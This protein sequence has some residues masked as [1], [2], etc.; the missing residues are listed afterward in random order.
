MGTVFAL[1]YTENAIINLTHIGKA[2]PIT[3]EELRAGDR[4][5]LLKVGDDGGTILHMEA[6]R[7][8]V[9]RGKDS[10]I[11]MQ[12][13]VLLVS[14]TGQRSGERLSVRIPED[15]DK[16]LVVLR[17]VPRKDWDNASPDARKKIESL[18]GIRLSSIRPNDTGPP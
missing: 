6:A 11:R 4:V 17:N 2:E 12:D 14:L 7:P 3:L 5:T 8:I 18:N 1:L 15:D 16:H 9:D 10:Q 13:K